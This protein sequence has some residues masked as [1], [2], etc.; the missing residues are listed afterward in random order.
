V[1]YIHQN[2]NEDKFINIYNYDVDVTIELLNKTDYLALFIE[3][4]IHTTL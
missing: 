3:M 4:S 2:K 1:Q